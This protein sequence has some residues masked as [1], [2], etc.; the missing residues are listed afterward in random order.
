MFHLRY[1][2]T[3]PFLLKHMYLIINWYSEGLVQTD[4]GDK[5]RVEY[6]C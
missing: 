1:Q 5:S 4:A 6:Y 2:S 3:G